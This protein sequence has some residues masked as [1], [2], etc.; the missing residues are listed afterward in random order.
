E[1]ASRLYESNPEVSKRRLERAID[2]AD[3]SLREARR[4]IMSMRLP[5]LENATLPEALNAIGHR[6]TEGSSIA[7]HLAVKGPVRQLS[8]EM[9][10]SL[11][12]VG[13]EAIANSVN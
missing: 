3:E 5:E 9:Q 1:A 10:A 2:Q 6:T 4:A 7:F 11:Y 12:L 8:Y 13:R